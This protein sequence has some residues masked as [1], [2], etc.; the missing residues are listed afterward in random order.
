MSATAQPATEKFKR[1]DK[2]LIAQKE[3]ANKSVYEDLES[4]YNVNI[5]F[6][7]FHNVEGFSEREYR[8]QRFYPNEFTSIVFTGRTA[9]EHFFRLCEDMRIKMPETTKYFCASE[10]TANYLQKFIFFRKRKVFNGTRS[11]N[12]MKAQIMRHKKEKFYL[13]CSEGGNPRVK[14][15]FDELKI[16]VQEAEMYRTVFTDLTDL[17][18]VKY[19]ILAFFTALEIQ[20]LFDNFPDFKQD[21]RRICAFGAV[22]RKAII[23]NGMKVD[24]E[25]GTP[26]VPS[27][28]V[29]LE[30]YLKIA[31]P[32]L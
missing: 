3:P 13:P 11:I 26:E 20:A 30:N 10:S 25:A 31:N 5:D 4:K 19:D 2:I 22:A 6:V 8:K 29:A 17:K 16:E 12:E 21:D 28:V 27:I 18:D 23:E 15:F 9:I 1:V 7:P 32:G 14:A 24:I